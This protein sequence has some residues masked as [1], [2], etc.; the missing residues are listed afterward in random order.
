LVL[1]AL[2]KRGSSD[3]GPERQVLR[4]RLVGLGRVLL[5]LGPRLPNPL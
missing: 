3:E 1:A 2:G 4:A 5:L